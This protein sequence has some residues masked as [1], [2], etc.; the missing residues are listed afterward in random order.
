MGYEN[1][2]SIFYRDNLTLE[3]YIKDVT[4][5]NRILNGK[6]TSMGKKKENTTKEEDKRKLLIEYKDTLKDVMKA[7]K[8]NLHYWKR[9]W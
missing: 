4:G 8:K 9:Y 7:K 6:I 2:E 1:P 5:D 3:Q